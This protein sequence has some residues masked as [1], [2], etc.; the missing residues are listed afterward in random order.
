MNNKKLEEL[1]HKAR[2]KAKAEALRRKDEEYNEEIRKKYN[3]LK[4]DGKEINW[5][6]DKKDRALKSIK[7]STKGKSRFNKLLDKLKD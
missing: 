6:S 7:K 2:M 4:E 5:S 3:K 1:E